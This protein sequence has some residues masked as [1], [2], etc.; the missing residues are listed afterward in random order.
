MST[1]PKRRRGG[2]LARNPT[3][4]TTKLPAW[5]DEDACH[6]CGLR[7]SVWRRGGV[8]G[9]SVAVYA[10]VVW[11]DGLSLVRTAGGDRIDAR[12]ALVN[13]RGSGP[14][15]SR[16]PVLWAM[17][18]AALSRWLLSHAGCA[19]LVDAIERG[20]DDIS[21]TLRSALDERAGLDTTSKSWGARQSLEEWAGLGD[22]W[23]DVDAGSWDD[24][25]A[26][27]EAARAAGLMDWGRAATS[28]AW[29]ESGWGDDDGFDWSTGEER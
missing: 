19:S 10:P 11:R 17:R 8:G 5:I 28:D 12:G 9:Y 25:A 14:Y 21:V 16:G 23:A 29:D 20:D 1:V 15:I 13:A 6:V 24:E 22:L 26:L 7:R 18:Q 2:G 3:I 4:K 27:D